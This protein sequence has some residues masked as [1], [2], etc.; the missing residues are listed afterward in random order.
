M[1]EIS[2]SEYSP[3]NP[4][5]TCIKGTIL[6]FSVQ[7]SENPFWIKALNEAGPGSDVL[8]IFNNGVSNGTLYWDTSFVEPGTYYYVSENNHH[9]SSTIEVKENDAIHGFRYGDGF[10]PPGFMFAVREA[11]DDG[12]TDNPIDRYLIRR[13]GA[14]TA[15][16]VR[17]LMQQYRETNTGLNYQYVDDN[18]VD[19]IIAHYMQFIDA[20]VESDLQGSLENALV[21]T[22]FQSSLSLLH[23]SLRSVSMVEHEIFEIQ[24]AVN[25]VHNRWRPQDLLVGGLA[26]AVLV[27]NI[28]ALL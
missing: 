11:N 7:A 18:V 5:L 15:S 26:L 12:D 22:G 24:Q 20:V 2:A 16:Q 28:I 10:D 21:R 9:I 6:I 25:D 3:V 17:S 1:S 13:I 27:L 23:E 4:P 19:D 14:R 8:G